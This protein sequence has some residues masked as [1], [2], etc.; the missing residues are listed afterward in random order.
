[1]LRLC[2]FP[3]SHRIRGYYPQHLK[4]Q[5]IRH[6]L[7]L[8]I[9]VYVACSEHMLQLML[10]MLERPQLVHLFLSNISVRIENNVVYNMCIVSFGY[11]H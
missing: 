3:F 6:L 1:M 5:I 7:V 2:S 4:Y 8:G 9:F 11:S 10:L